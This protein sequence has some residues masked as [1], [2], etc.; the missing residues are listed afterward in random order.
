MFI[1]SVSGSTGSRELIFS[2]G[3]KVFRFQN[4]DHQLNLFTFAADFVVAEQK[5]A[6]FHISGT[7]VDGYFIPSKHIDNFYD[8]FLYVGKHKMAHTLVNKKRLEEIVDL[9]DEGEE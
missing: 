5:K 2:N 7:N 8:L 9:L 1:M 4:N 6:G 3:R